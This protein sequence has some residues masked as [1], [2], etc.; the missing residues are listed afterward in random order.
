MA[1]LLA[2]SLYHIHDEIEDILENRN[3]TQ[4]KGHDEEPSYPLKEDQ[5]ATSA[6]ESML[7]I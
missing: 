5:S 6:D 1:E 4:K 2:T 3:T 7:S